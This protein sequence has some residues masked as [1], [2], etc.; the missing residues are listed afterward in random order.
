MLNDWMNAWMNEILSVVCQN[1]A[2]NS[3]TLLSL[4]EWIRNSNL[5]AFNVELPKV[6]KSN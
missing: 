6:L 5:F 2:Q 1:L 4:N 3:S